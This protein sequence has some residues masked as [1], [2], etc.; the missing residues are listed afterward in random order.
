[1]AAALRSLHQVLYPGQG[2]YSLTYLHFLQSY[3]HKTHQESTYCAHS[4]WL[5][6]SCLLTFTFQ[7]CVSLR[8]QIHGGFVCTSSSWEYI[9]V[10]FA[11]FD[12][13]VLFAQFDDTVLEQFF[14]I[15][16]IEDFV[17][18]LFAILHDCFVYLELT[19]NYLTGLYFS[20]FPNFYCLKSHFTC[21][22][23]LHNPTANS[24]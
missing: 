1:M 20:A 15:Y 7:W 21:H 13:T 23:R 2:H 18:C 16:I 4:K 17:Q 5:R 9:T 8:F 22:F 12:D 3:G 14:F 10:L 6:S 24:Y 19:T 11:Q